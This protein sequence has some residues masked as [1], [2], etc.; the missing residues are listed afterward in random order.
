MQIRTITS[1]DH[2]QLAEIYRQ[3]IATGNA[4]FQTVPTD[5]ETWDKGHLEVCR[6]AVFEGE[7]M[8]GW[9]ALSPVSS[10]CVYA[11]VAEL[12]IYIAADYRGKGIGKLLLTKLVEDSENAGFWTLQAG[13]FPENAASIQLHK[14]CGFREIGYRER[15]GQMNGIWRNNIILERRSNIVG[16]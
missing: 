1:A 13:I 4:T 15:I 2:P 3:G 10:R 6:L 16:V 11:G 12:S 7:K 9:A 14:S 8:A 5:W